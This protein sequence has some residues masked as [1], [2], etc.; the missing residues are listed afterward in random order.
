MFQPTRQP[1]VLLVLLTLS[2]S[3]CLVSTAVVRNLPGTNDARFFANASV[4]PSPA[5][6]YFT[7]A[8][9]DSWGQRVEVE[10]MDGDQFNLGDYLEQSP[11]LSMLVLRGDSVLYEWYAEDYDAASKFTSFSMVKSFV[12]VLVGIAIEEGKIPGVQTRITD[13]FPE[14]ADKEGMEEVT[15]AHLLNMTAGFKEKKS[16]LNP[17]AEVVRY[18]YG[19]HL[20][21]YTKY[22]EINT[23]VGSTFKYSPAASTQLLAFILQ[24]STGKKMPE[25]LY[26][27]IWKE[28]GTEDEALWSMD[29]EGGNAKAFCCLNAR[30]RDYARFGR[31]MLHR[32]NW[33]GK[34][35]VPADWF[36]TCSEVDSGYCQQIDWTVEQPRNRYRYHWWQGMQG[37]GDF[38]AIGLYGQMIHVF[39]RE[40][41]IIVSFAKRKGFDLDRVELNVNYQIVEQFT[42][43]YVQNRD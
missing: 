5:P 3:S 41:F 33:E 4:P 11:N 9:D 7:E 23:E 17:K 34:Q 39:P 2:C 35:I 13:Y 20:E 1:L 25:L 26:E 36:N 21:K 27:K 16:L 32:G 24:K 28:I 19:K 12:S 40:N 42:E 15:I 43:Q 22:L 37:K 31:L 29:R 8:H 14:L 38:R 10:T 6:F 30:A 18:Y